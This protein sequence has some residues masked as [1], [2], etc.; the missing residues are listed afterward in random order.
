ML[1]FDPSVSPTVGWLLAGAGVIVVGIAKSGF[2]GGVG[3]AAVP[4]FALAFGA[5]RGNAILLPLLIAADVFSVCHHWGA[6][7]RR[8]LRVLA[9][10]TLAG[11]LLGS[12]ILFLLV[13]PGP[14]HALAV[15]RQ[16]S[17]DALNLIT[18]II[19]ILYVLLD[20]VRQRLAPRWHFVPDNKTGFGAGLAVG[21][22]STLAHA[23]GPVAAIFLLGQQISKQVFIGTTVIY[24]FGVNTLKLLPYVGLNLI[25]WDSIAAGLW[26]CPLVPIGTALGAWLCRRMNER[27][28]RAVIMAIVLLT[29]LQMTLETL[30]GVKLAQVVERMM[31]PVG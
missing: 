30:T 17:E 22:I 31:H 19:S 23:A 24:F 15:G 1:A 14:A 2:G 8:L 25:N 6:W 7:D 5:Q 27:V 28:F 26:L 13:V 21:A 3:I 29:G 20:L 10:G 4:L 18:G 11:I 9:P 16:R 12:A